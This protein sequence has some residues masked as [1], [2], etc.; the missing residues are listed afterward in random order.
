MIELLFCYLLGAL[1]VEATSEI[2]TS[3]DL[4]FGFRS[5]LKKIVYPEVPNE[6]LNGFGRYVIA[7]FEKLISCGYCTSVWVAAFLSLALPTIYSDITG[8]GYAGSEPIEQACGYMI[9]VF[10]MHR[11]SNWIHVLFELVKKGRVKTFDIMYQ[12]NENNENNGDS[13]GSF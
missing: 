6:N 2:I 5:W 9:S 4:T 1:A 3:S 7:W 11:L 12:N 13:N 8:L 10:V